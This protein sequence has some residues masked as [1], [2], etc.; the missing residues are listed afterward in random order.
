MFHRM[1]L[2]LPM[3][4]EKLHKEHNGS[5]ETHFSGDVNY[6]ARNCQKVINNDTE[7]LINKFVGN[8]EG[9]HTF[10]D[11]MLMYILIF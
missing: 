10:S 11:Q 3:K 2:Q 4:A 1:V 7:L 9:I 5:G 6:S 8:M